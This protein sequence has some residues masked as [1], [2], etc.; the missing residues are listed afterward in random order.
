MLDRYNHSWKKFIVCYIETTL[1][2]MNEFSVWWILSLRSIPVMCPVALHNESCL[3]AVDVLSFWW[4]SGGEWR[5]DE[6]KPLVLCV[7]FCILMPGRLSSSRLIFQQDTRC[8][9][10]TTVGDWS[11]AVAGLH[12]WNSLPATFKTDHQLQTVSATSEN[13]FI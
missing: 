11:F 1:L 8:S 2:A 3:Y 13:T 4:E 6:S 12:V 5:K 7:P 9:M 10:H